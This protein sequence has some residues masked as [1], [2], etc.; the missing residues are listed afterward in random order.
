MSDDDTILT[1]QQIEAIDRKERGIPQ[2]H[3]MARV[4]VSHEALRAAL[5][6]ARQQLAVLAQ[7]QPIATAPKTGTA[8]LAATKFLGMP[9]VERIWWDKNR[10]EG[11]QGEQRFDAWMP[12]PAPPSVHASAT[13][14][15]CT[16]TSDDD[17]LWTTDCGNAYSFVWDGPED[18][19]QKF[20]GYCG[21]RL[22]QAA[23]VEPV[24]P[25]DAT[26]ATP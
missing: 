7:W 12:L 20:C 13:T 3:E 1:P 5:F 19:G 6:H 25:N 4:I 10:W 26:G 16:W 14:A 21:K 22:I 18:N 23:Y 17:G 11:A 15:T 2:A 9:C 24:E 8:F